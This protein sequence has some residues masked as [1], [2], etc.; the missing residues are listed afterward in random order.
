MAYSDINC[1]SCIYHNS[2]FS[3]PGICD[4]CWDFWPDGKPRYRCYTSI[5]MCCKLGDVDIDDGPP[6]EE[7]EMYNHSRF[8]FDNDNKFGLKMMEE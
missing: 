3:D 7:C 8:E 5:C 6:C 2:A 1:D 4:I